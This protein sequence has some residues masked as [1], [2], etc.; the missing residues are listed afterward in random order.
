MQLVSLL[1]SAIAQ[2]TSGGWR[3]WCSYGWDLAAFA[4]NWKAAKSRR[5]LVVKLRREDSMGL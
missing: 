2:T 4:T 1:L 5:S 3:T